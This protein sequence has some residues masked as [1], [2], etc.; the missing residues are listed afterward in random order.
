MANVLKF[1]NIFKHKIIVVLMIT[2]QRF[3]VVSTITAIALVAGM[4]AFM[5]FQSA[6][7][8]ANGEPTIWTEGINAGQIHNYIYNVPA[9]AGTFGAALLIDDLAEK[10]NVR[11]TLTDPA[12][13]ATVCPVTI[14]GGVGPAFLSVSECN[15]PGP[16]PGIWTVSVQGGPIVN[17]AVGYAVA[18]DTD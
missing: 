11:L 6:D 4:I 13:V 3:T 18:A 2:R 10:P 7:A 5:P 12:G 8:S 17:N 9:G 1:F 15:I 16:L 14:V